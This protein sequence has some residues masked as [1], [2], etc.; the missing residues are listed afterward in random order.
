MKKIFPVLALMFTISATSPVY[1]F[2]FNSYGSCS[3]CKVI[4]QAENVQEEA[5]QYLL[6]PSYLSAEF[7]ELYSKAKAIIA[8]EL[9]AEAADALT[10]EEFALQILAQP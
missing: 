10:V 4:L 6:D 9:G 3:G 1:A 2:A 7:A 5:A 8:A